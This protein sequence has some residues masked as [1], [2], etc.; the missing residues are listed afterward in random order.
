LGHLFVALMFVWFVKEFILSLAR[1]PRTP[2]FRLPQHRDP[3]R[4]RFKNE[5]ELAGYV[6]AKMERFERKLDKRSQG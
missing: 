1:K 5:D 2:R 4:P 3:T 6:T